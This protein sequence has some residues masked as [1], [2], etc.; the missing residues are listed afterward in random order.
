MPHGSW[1]GAL[2]F[3]YSPVVMLYTHDIVGSCCHVHE[4]IATHLVRCGLHNCRSWAD[5]PFGRQQPTRSRQKVGMMRSA[6]GPGVLEGDVPYN[7]SLI[8]ESVRDGVS[9]PLNHPKPRQILAPEASYLINI[10][11]HSY[12][13]GLRYDGTAYCGWQLQPGFPTIQGAIERALTVALSEDRQR[14]MV[15]AAG[16]TDRGVHATGQ[17]GLEGSCLCA[18]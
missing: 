8:A 1:V 18:Y 10:G 11:I 14:L 17:V 6:P 3:P 2:A 4:L 12:R 15:C 13:L 7:D 16:R 5:K 9:P